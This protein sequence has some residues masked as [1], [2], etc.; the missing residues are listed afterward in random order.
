M[1]RKVLPYVL[2]GLFVWYLPDLFLGS[3]NLSNYLF[4]EA[5][6]VPTQNVQIKVVRKSPYFPEKYAVLGSGVPGLRVELMDVSKDTVMSTVTDGDGLALFPQLSD[7]TYQ[8]NIGKEVEFTPEDIYAI[9][10]KGMSIFEPGTTFKTTIPI[11]TITRDV[12][13]SPVILD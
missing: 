12:Y 9:E 13:L 3:K 11:V 10:H 6:A 4:R 8:I 5:T 2:F 1:F 7:G